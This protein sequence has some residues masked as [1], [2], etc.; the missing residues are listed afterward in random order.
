MAL[1]PYCKSLNQFLFT[2]VIVGTASAGVD[3]SV[4]A[5]ILDV[6]KNKSNSYMQAVCFCFGLGSVFGPLLVEPYI[7]EVQPITTLHKYPS[8]ST[9]SDSVS[10]TSHIVIPFWI[11]A[12]GTAKMA[13]VQFLAYWR[14][15][16]VQQYEKLQT[17]KNYEDPKPSTHISTFYLRSV[18]VLGA[19]L[20]CFEGGLE[21][22]TFNYLQTFAIHLPR[23]LTKS[24]AAFLNAI[25]NSAFTVSRLLA[26]FISTK[27]STRKMLIINFIL[28][29]I[30]NGL[31]VM[32][33]YSVIFLYIGVLVIGYGFGS[34]Y[35]V[36]ITLY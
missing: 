3:V 27:V 25:L 6:W 11:A 31:M 9:V 10:G 36:C 1:V 12:F 19:L 30:G 15:R 32:V 17:M 16:K 7:R 24:S 22:N 28:I 5:I 23:R 35:P 18:V 8:S 2:Q 13:S 20:L 26:I 14:T 4:N 21:L 29:M 34:T 33:N